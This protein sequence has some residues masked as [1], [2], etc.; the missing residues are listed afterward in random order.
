MSNKNILIFSYQL[1]VGGSELNALKLSK[2]MP[3]N[4]LW[5]TIYNKKNNY[6]SRSNSISKFI[7]FGMNVT[8]KKTSV[9]QFVIFIIKLIKIVKKERIHTIY[10]IGFLPSLVSSFVKIFFN[11]NLITTRR[12]ADKANNKKYLIL[13]SIINFYS[14]TIETNSKDIFKKIKKNFLLK[15]KIQLV[16]NIIPDSVIKKKNKIFDK[17]KSI[18]GIVANLRPVKNPKMIKLVVEFFCKRENNISFYI[19]GRDFNNYYKNLKTKYKNKVISKKFIPNE[20]MKKFYNSIDVLLITSFFESSPNVILE[21]FANGVPVVS[22]PVG[23]K[24]YIKNN[25]NGEI[26][27]NFELNNLVFCLKKVINS[28]NRYSKNAKKTF[29]IKYDF[30]KNINKIKSYF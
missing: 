16:E 1:I 11:I 8:A 13:N 22:T 20:K 10:A 17:N 18:I 27:R 24:N 26:S 25:Y 15:K 5:L 21:A 6:Y 30:K 9:L 23:S 4:F 29:L 3:H 2:I 7:N 19:V 14:N 12:G 28:K